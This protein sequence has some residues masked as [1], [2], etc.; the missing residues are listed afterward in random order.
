MYSC[1]YRERRTDRRRERERDRKTDRQRETETD[2]NRQ[3]ERER[4]REIKWYNDK[5]D[6]KEFPR[7]QDKSGPEKKKWDEE[8]KKTTT[9]EHILVPFLQRLIIS[10]SILEGLFK[11]LCVCR[12]SDVCVALASTVKPKLVFTCV[13]CLH[14]HSPRCARSPWL[15]YRRNG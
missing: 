12:V 9:T 4:E 7:K 6:T 5:K 13:T 11:Y 2:R 3:T 1:Q 14:A 10:G 8:R 15:A